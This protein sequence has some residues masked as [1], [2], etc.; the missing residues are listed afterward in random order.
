MAIVFVAAWY[1]EAL[2]QWEE[3]AWVDSADLTPSARSEEGMKSYFLFFVVQL[4]FQLTLVVGQV[5]K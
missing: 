3:P 4:S 2:P 1:P 5:F